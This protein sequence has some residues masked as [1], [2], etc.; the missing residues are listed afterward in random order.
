MKIGMIGTGNMGKILIEA[1][2]DGNAISP[3]DVFIFN[4]TLSK[5][6]EIKEN[7]PNINICSNAIEIAKEADLIFLCVKPH[8]M[9]GVSKNIS[10]VLTKDKCVVSITS[11]I[12][13][14][15][16]ETFFNCSVARII[17]SITNR[18]LAG[19]SL[20]S[21]GRNCTEAWKNQL[22][23]F[24]KKFSTP[25]EIEDNITRVA[26]DI[27]SCGP[28]FFCYL[29]RKFIEGA[30]DETEIDLE[31]ATKLASEML[32]GL[33]ELLKKGYYTLPTLQEKVSVKGGITGEGI[34]VLERQLGDTFNQLFQATHAKYEDDQ[35]SLKNLVSGHKNS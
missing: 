29:T 28:A 33:G 25:L 34:N 23:N 4:R 15:Q 3:E 17:P 2:I 14:D 16:L 5:A 8:D 12:S 22:E 21:F 6:L 13:P 24:Y 27:V 7:Y 11:P 10:P 1:M 19:V 35:L 31:T 32:I 30:V 9:Y 20:F 18:A 26:S